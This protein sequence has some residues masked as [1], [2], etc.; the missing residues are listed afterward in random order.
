MRP[1]VCSCLSL[2]GFR[3]PSHPPE[4]TEATP[5]TGSQA[6]E[7][8]SAI[9]HQVS[10]GKREV[11]DSRAGWLPGGEKAL[12][13]TGHFFLTSSDHTPKV[14]CECELSILWVPGSQEP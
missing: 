5:C 13:E 1:S 6:A 7:A 12:V 4:D 10:E 3:P 9:A 2:L 14:S 11:L 8:K